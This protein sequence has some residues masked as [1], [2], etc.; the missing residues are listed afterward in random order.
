MVSR[1][2]IIIGKGLIIMD[3]LLYRSIVD[4]SKKYSLNLVRYKLGTFILKPAAIEIGYVSILI[5]SA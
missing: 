3:K 2:E 4:E 1:D 5:L